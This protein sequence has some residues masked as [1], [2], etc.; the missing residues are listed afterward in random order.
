MFTRE[1][2]E[3][4]D[5]LKGAGPA[6]RKKLS[7]LGIYTAADLLLYA[8]RS[9]E[10]RSQQRCL[11][12]YALGPVNCRVQVTAHEWFGY[13]RMKSLKIWVQDEQGTR[14]VLVCFNRGFLEQQWPEGSSGQ[15]WGKFDFRYGSLQSSSFDL[16]LQPAPGSILPVYPLTEGLGQTSLRKLARQA[17]LHWG[18]VDDEIPAR[19]LLKQGLPD[20][21]SALRGLH[22]PKT[23]HEAEQA[24]RRMVYEEL[25]YMQLLILRRNIQRRQQKLE[26]GKLNSSLVDALRQRLPFEL[27]PDQDKVL[28]EIAT[29]LHSPWPM[30][31]LLQGDVG[32]GKTL[33]AFMSALYSIASGGQA[34]IMAPTEL[35]ARQHAE[36]AALLL[37]PLG[38]RLAFLSG[39]VSDAARRPLLAALAAGEIDLVLGT[40]AL[41]SDEVH[42]K[43]LRFVVV[44][45]QHRFGVLQRLALG[46]KGKAP[47]LLM[48]SATPIPRTLAL[49]AFG[50][51][52]VSTIRTMP[53]GR[54]AIITHLARQGNEDKVYSFIEKELRAGNR[55]YFV[56]PLVD[57]SDK[58]ELKDAEAMFQALGKRFPAFKGGLIHARLPEDS[59]R[60]TMHSFSRGELQYLVATSV[61]EVGV[62][63]PQATC[64]V[65]E[66]A[67]RF[68]L[69]ALHQL[70][71]RVGRGS[72]QSYCFLVWS[73][74]L[75]NEGKQ[76]V[77]A[78]KNTTD[79]FVIAEEDLRIRGPGEITG[80]SQAGALR[81]SF[82]D[83]V[84]DAAVLEAARQ[85]ALDVLSADP[86]LL[87]A[88]GSLIRQVLERASP[89]AEKTAGAS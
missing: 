66:H 22:Q 86:E 11:R 30:A 46:A 42:Y 73:E 45:E 17:L 70:R 89:F 32:S 88:D 23:M 62:D 16:D 85:D 78:M 38:V 74:K 28:D 3:P 44:D 33:V 8:P 36:N 26:R 43:N 21:K 1:L 81:L 84:R 4:L 7:R 55:A 9:W 18:S 52:A 58:L 49:T 68:G 48:M 15:L 64:M 24:W 20:K 31:R 54:K 80:T 37:E 5:G 82:A 41:F 47:D 56:Y 71:G 75:G 79:G 69:A 61:V 35:L 25:F 67:E 14:A 2:L 10:D 87:S 29:D 57:R 13:G 6:L 39:N 60:A 50:D 76:R 34:A 27:T 77:M 59:K 65:I 63:V 40:H 12:E 72:A 83:P 53:P 19:L 51:L